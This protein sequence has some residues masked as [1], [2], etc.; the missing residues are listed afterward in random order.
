MQKKKMVRLVISGFALTA[1]VLC[2]LFLLLKG[3]RA[4]P[5]E[6]SGTLEAAEDA[7]N[8]A[9][10]EETSAEPAASG[11]GQ[12]EAAEE[13]PE[14][15]P[16]EEELLDLRTKEVLS[17]MTL[18]EKV[19]Q[20]FFVAP[21]SLV[22]TDP[23]V[24]TDMA[25][26]E[27]LHEYPVGGVVYFAK[28]LLDAEQT[29]QMLSIAQEN[30]RSGQNLPLFLAVDEEGGRVRRI[31]KNENFHVESVD[32]MGTLAK[33][34]DTK[35]IFDA[36]DTIGSYLNELGFNVDFAPDADVITN[37]ENAVIGDRSFGTDPSLVSDMAASY[38]DGLHNNGILSC[39]KH[40]PGHGGTAEDSHTGAAYSYKTRDELYETELVPFMYAEE[41][42]VD[43]VMVAHICVPEVT[44]E[45]FVPAF[46]KAGEG[47]KDIPATFSK[48]LVT[49]ILREEM[50]YQGIIITD[51]LSMGAITD[52]YDSNE[53]AVYALEAG[54]D[55]L[56]MPED[57]HGA[58]EAVLTAVQDGRIS[59]ERLD[60]SVY[61]IVRTKILL[62][63]K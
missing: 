50:G 18:E 23:V 4:L 61:R 19:A 34:G 29:T 3:H 40:F 44:G 6:Q 43:F 22:E 26:A 15:E 45:E 8:M 21:E 63:D 14:E 41:H 38:S 42:G 62:E 57:F 27:A 11:S 60:E 56:L 30:Y 48:I 7:G 10:E 51:S 17:S 36:A 24:E 25:F 53:A 47:T 2:M 13:P 49:D 28:N 55:M 37:P 33:N 20:L 5:E 52:Y 32:A 12:S 39:Y 35:V 1:V 54:C 46:P 58:Y 9:K 31:G 16:S 59:K